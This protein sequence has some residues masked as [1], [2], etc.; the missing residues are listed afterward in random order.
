MLGGGTVDTAVSIKLQVDMTMCIAA[1]FGW[2][3]TNED[4]RHMTFLI[5]AGSTLEKAGVEVGGKIASQA[6]VKMINQYLKGATLTFVK[7]MF[8]KIGVTF[9][10]TSLVKAIPFGVGM[11]I[12]S[13]ANYALT[14]YVGKTAEGWFT[15][16]RQMPDERAA[17]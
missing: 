13:S 8:A 1:T 12:G 5:A 3:L 15:I 9:T 17:A 14:R 4:A 16:E 6:G 2:D 7:Q 10:R 11:L